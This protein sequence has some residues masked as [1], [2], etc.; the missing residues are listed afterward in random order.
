MVLNVK[1]DR[2][3]VNFYWHDKFFIAAVSTSVNIRF[4]NT[5]DR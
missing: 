3:D 1:F 4:A 5:V 2:K